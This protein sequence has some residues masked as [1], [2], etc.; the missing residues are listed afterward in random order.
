MAQK[1]GDCYVKKVFRQHGSLV[2]TLPFHV[3]QRLSIERG[4]YVVFE[5]NN[6]RKSVKFYRWRRGVSKSRAD[7]GGARLQD[8]QRRLHAT[9]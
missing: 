6:E 1:W 5:V 3:R 7:Y 9:R 2:V 8:S 4:D